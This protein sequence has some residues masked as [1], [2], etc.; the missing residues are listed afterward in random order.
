MLILIFHYYIPTAMLKLKTN[1]TTCHTIR[2][3]KSKTKKIFKIMTKSNCYVSRDSL[4]A[5]TVGSG[6]C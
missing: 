4:K 6:F 2:A 1:T 3:I 5:V